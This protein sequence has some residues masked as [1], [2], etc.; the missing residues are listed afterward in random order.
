VFKNTGPMTRYSVQAGNFQWSMAP[1]QTA[2]TTIAT[3]ATTQ[4][5]SLEVAKLTVAGERMHSTNSAPIGAS[6]GAYTILVTG[7]GLGAHSCGE[8]FI[9]ATENGI[10][11]TFYKV[12][13]VTDLTGTV[14]YSGENGVALS[15]VSGPSMGNAYGQ[16]TF[17]QTGNDLE[18]RSTAGANYVY[19]HIRQFSQTY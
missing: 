13:F 18:A 11:T 15:A 1:S 16:L 8:I 3:P 4:L 14:K 12:M 7:S 5:M 6:S 19:V 10:N 2:G 17:Q 9:R